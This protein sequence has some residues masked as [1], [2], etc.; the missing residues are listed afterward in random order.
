M[1]SPNNNNLFIDFIYIFISILIAI[2]LVKTG[3]LMRILISVSGIEII[4]SFI[5]GIFFTSA[6]T[7]APAMAVLG[8]ISQANSLFHTAFFGASGAVIGDII[9]FQFIKDQLSD[10][11]SELL[12]HNGI[13]KR[14]K[15]LLKM[16]YF[17]WSTF[18]LGGFILASPLPDE[19][20]I[21]I[22]GFSKMKISLFIIISFFFNFIGIFIIGFIA[23]T[24]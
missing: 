22:L 7:T 19:L 11:L 17:R 4:G 16:K 12:K 18:L 20:G 6:F 1:V 5:A 21:S 10:H 9:I 24:L 2:F 13:W 3:F 23:R 8:E 14:T 15:L